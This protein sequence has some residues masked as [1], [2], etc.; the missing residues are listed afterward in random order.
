MRTHSPLVTSRLASGTHLPHVVSDHAR[1]SRRPHIVVRAFI[2]LCLVALSAMLTL[3]ASPQL[4][5]QTVTIDSAQRAQRHSRHDITRVEG[6]SRTTSQRATRSRTTSLRATRSRV[7]DLR[8]HAITEKKH[9]RHTR[10]LRLY[11]QMLSVSERAGDSASMGMALTDLGEMHRIMGRN[12]EALSV[13]MRAAPLVARCGSNSTRILFHGLQGSLFGSLGRKEE[14]MSQLLAGMRIAEQESDMVAIADLH[15]KIGAEHQRNGF[16]SQAQ[17]S[18][19]HS[20]D[21]A[22]RIAHD[23]AVGRALTQLGHIKLRQRNFEEALRLFERC[24]EHARDANDS[25]RITTAQGNIALVHMQQGRYEHALSLFRQSLEGFDE[26][27]NKPLAIIM[28]SRIGVACDKL[29]RTAEAMQAFRRCLQLNEHM[30]DPSA[31]ALDLINVGMQH[32]RLGQHGEALDC[33]QRSAALAETSGNKGRLASALQFLGDVHGARGSHEQAIEYFDRSLVVRRSLGGGAEPAGTHIII[34]KLQ[35][36]MKQW[37][38]AHASL[39]RALEIA[40]SNNDR[41]TTLQALTA[42]AQTLEQEHRRPE[43]VLAAFE[44]AVRLA[45]EL[46]ERDRLALLLPTLAHIHMQLGNDDTARVHAARALSIAEELAMPERIRLAAAVLGEVCMKQGDHRKAYEHLKRA[47]VLQDT[48][49]KQENIRTINEM[50]AKYASAEQQR[51]IARLEVEKRGQQL[52]LERRAKLLA[53]QQLQAAHDR[54]YADQLEQ[55]RERHLLEIAKQDMD[56]ALGEKE[57]ELQKALRT[58]ALQDRQAQAAIASREVGLRN[59]LLAGV[60]LF[61]I[62]GFLG[63]KRMQSRRMEAT[64]RAEAAEYQLRATEAEALALKYQVEARERQAQR[65]SM[66]QLI[67]TQERER[68]RIAGSL[69]DSLGQDLLVIKNR[70]LFALQ[71]E[72]LPADARAEFEQIE[73]MATA[74][75]QNVRTISYDLRPYQLDR[76]GLTKTLRATVQR[77]AETSGIV[78]DAVI[79]DIDQALSKD[80]ETNVYRIVQ[81]SLNNVMKHSGAT[82]ASVHITRSA[83]HITLT[84]CDN[85]RGMNGASTSNGSSPANG[86]SGFGL[87]NMRER[88]E[89]LGGT[90]RLGTDEGGGVCVTIELPIERARVAPSELKRAS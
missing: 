43:E 40:R 44:Q 78:F 60:V 71:N 26:N 10:A 1:R 90:L 17:E 75:L 63:V 85:G 32:L 2:A 72:S 45:G 37:E 27:E 52:E 82:N 74:A 81:E 65:R 14:A 7:L 19:E 49:M 50:E 59:A 87:Q 11:E 88:A 55:E 48:L 61:L 68:S 12:A 46:G 84:I 66:K 5:A 80:D 35:I 28:Y 79:D 9:G 29:G 64:L 51:S 58:R 21:V 76:L 13:T 34:G 62:A 36:L 18:Y 53:L 25:V 86:P 39:Q 20:F 23:G 4:H 15:L 38:K 47:S 6:R 30:G 70:T 56:L 57:L 24:L 41:P 73:E 83:Q 69:H 89:M 22:E 67:D 33:G 16:L 42:I 8:A 54:L 77:V 31:I 3:P